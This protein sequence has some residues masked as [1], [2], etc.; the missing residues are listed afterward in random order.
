[1]TTRQEKADPRLTRMLGWI[2]L[3]GGVGILVY[4]ILAARGISL[5]GIGVAAVG[6]VTISFLR[7]DSEGDGSSGKR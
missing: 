1:M 7:S 3:V 5:V 6:A 2:A 4:E